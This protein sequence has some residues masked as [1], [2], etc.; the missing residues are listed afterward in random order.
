MPSRV[1]VRAVLAMALLSMFA[2]PSRA[3]DAPAWARAGEPIRGGRYPAL[4]PDGRM[5]VFG[6]LG[7]L[8]TVPSD[9][10]VARRLTASTSYERSP[11][12][13]PDGKWIAFASNR[14]GDF[15]LFVIPAEGGLPRRLTWHSSD[16]IPCAFSPDNRRVIFRS[17]REVLSSLYSIPVE[18]G[19]PARLSRLTWTEA[20]NASP[21]PDGKSM[22]MNLGP[23]SRQFW[24]RIGYK[25]SNNADVWRLDL[26]SGH[27]ARWTTWKGDDN[28]PL[29]GPDGR[30]FYYVADR[31]GRMPNLY[32]QDG[33]EGAPRA[34]THF[35]DDP[36]RFPCLAAD[37]SKIAYEHDL[38]LWVTD[39][40]TGESH[41]TPIQ[42]GADY[43]ASL[44]ETRT[45][46]RDA[47]E[48]AVS[49][50]SR[51]IALVVR[52]D[53]FVM[54][55]DGGETRP[56]THGPERD[57]FVSWTPD[58]RSL[59]YVTDKTGVAQLWVVGADG[60]GAPRALTAG[61]GEKGS[62]LV[63]PDGKTVVYFSG[64]GSVRS[65]PLGGGPESTLVSG[66]LGN[67][68]SDCTLAISPDSRWLAYTAAT[69]REEHEIWIVPLAGG[70]GVNVTRSNH[71]SVQPCWSR[72]GK[73]LYFASNRKGH[74]K[75]VVQEGNYE[76]F[77]IP[78]VPDSAKFSESR[79]DSLFLPEAPR[80]EGASEAKGGGAAKASVPVVRI[81]FHR[82]DRRFQRLFESKGDCVEPA[83]S[84]DGKTVVFIADETAGAQ[85]Y[86]VP[87]EG[88]RPK[89]LTQGEPLQNRLSQGGGFA[90]PGVLQWDKE[91]KKVFVLAGSTVKSIPLEGSAAEVAY[92]ARVTINTPG[93]YRQMLHEAWTALRDYYYDDKFHGVDWESVG[94]K[95]EARAQFAA[96]HIDFD[97]VLREMVGELNSS[98]TGANGPALTPEQPTAFLGCEF[99]APIAGEIGARIVRV[100]RDGPLD[101]A[102]ARA[103]VGE[104]ILAVDGLPLDDQARDDAGLSDKVGR[105]VR[106]L[107]GPAPLARGALAAGKVP[108][109][110]E[111]LVK[112]LAPGEHAA[113]RYNDWSE[114]RKE[115]VHAKV[116]DKFVYIHLPACG[117]ADIEKFK[118]ELERD[119]DPAGGLILDV[120]W[121]TGGSI[122]EALLTYLAQRPY[123]FRQQ[124]GFPRHVTP[125]FAWARPTV[126]MQ[127]ENS[128]SNAEVIANGFREL[129]LGK[130]VGRTSYGWLI[131]TGSRR[132]L[133]GSSIRMPGRGCYSLRGEDTET[134]GGV[135]T[136]V[137]CE[138]SPEDDAAGRDPQLDKA[139]E[140][141]SEQVKR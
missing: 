108:G 140:T 99:E 64:Y 79:L 112:G 110:R 33:P 107:I 124:R 80:K 58:S 138:N 52:G 22:L 126:L 122:D 36:V 88:G 32:A 95:Y 123:Q 141:L 13:S 90:R 30:T 42:A 93:E 113:L 16:D 56:V 49:P 8:W 28:W 121:N 5:L 31:D 102:N 57:R 6:Y 63:S 115:Y 84:P 82:I 72:D 19:V 20:S 135:K 3:G 23:Q 27:Y 75:G 43:P 89:A 50:D 15:D 119:M 133:D 134:W 69:S 55:A 128:L 86:S 29:C 46:S 62:P 73:Y 38:G 67:E 132:L 34:L 65:I 105:R 2:S 18:G 109:T 54:P 114:A 45:L 25:G 26:D 40:R 130:I 77:R 60:S 127:N 59:V 101:Q 66:A 129:G 4:S 12:F 74:S 104:Y 92:A 7:D 71:D 91:G 97:D 98:H 39:L 118:R 70:A 14:Y 41:E 68:E 94:R 78:L 96:H 61:P 48:M 47:T 83:V 137:D 76:L 103:R 53:L 85:V 17:G 117:P 131:G 1:P 139:I 136:D 116:G 44:E 100:F 120:R 81:D 51:K 11:V 37:G 9:G 87:A 111:V 35:T 106:L 10:G 24:W 125:A 21:T